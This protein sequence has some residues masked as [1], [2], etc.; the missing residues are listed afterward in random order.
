LTLVLTLTLAGAA[1]ASDFPRR[2]LMVAFTPSDPRSASD[3][4]GAQHADYIFNR[5]YLNA[6]IKGL[7]DRDVDG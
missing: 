4:R 6:V 1:P 7:D 5:L 3:R 2:F